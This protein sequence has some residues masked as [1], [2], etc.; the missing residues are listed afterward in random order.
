[1][2]IWL[3]RDPAEKTEWVLLSEVALGAFQSLKQACMS[4]PVLAF[5]DYTKDFLLKTDAFKE[6]LGVVLSQKQ[7]RWALNT[8]LPMVAEPSLFMKRTIILQNLNS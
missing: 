2:N 1:M 6:G 3:G 8:W 5:A 4:A 7:A